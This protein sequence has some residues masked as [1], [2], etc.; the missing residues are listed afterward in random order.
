MFEPHLLQHQVAVVTGGGTGI[1]LA[2]AKRLGSLGA[3]VAIASRDSGHLEEGTA[4]LR[5]AGVDA[6]AIQL[7]VRKPEQ[8]DEM[9]ERTVKHFGSL[10]ILVNNAAGNFICRA[11]DLSPN[12]WNAVIGIVL[13]GTFY[14]SRA[15]GRYMIGRKR[16]GSIVSILANYLWT[17]RPGTIHSADA[18]PGRDA[19]APTTSA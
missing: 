19:L 12:G 3:S 2:I 1:G 10:D 15:V 8:V 7:D 6:L 5:A 14:C 18:Q 13:N 9:V 16:G 11:E 4:A 17:G